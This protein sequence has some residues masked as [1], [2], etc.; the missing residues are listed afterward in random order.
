MH[1]HPAI[2]HLRRALLL[3]TLLALTACAQQQPSKP[4]KTPNMT[5]LS[6]RIQPLFEKTKT[7]CF[8][9]F[10]IDVPA[11]T[12]IVWGSVSVP[13]GVVIAKGDASKLDQMVIRYETELKAAVRFPRTKGVNQYIETIGGPMK[14]Q[15]TV[16]GY[17]GF[18]G[19]GLRIYSYLAMGPDLVQLDALPMEKNKARAI[20]TLNDMASRLRPRNEDE[21]P[22]EPGMCIEH[23]F[24]SDSPTDGPSKQDLIQIG[25]RL[26]EF[27]DVHL[28]IQLSP[29]T[30]AFGES[31]TFKYQMEKAKKQD[32]T[33]YFK[34]KYLREGSGRRIHE[35]SDGY[36]ALTRT[37]DEASSKSHHAFIMDFQGVAGDAL[38]PYADIQL[39][40][41]VSG[42][43][44]GRDGAGSAK[45][46]ITD[47]EALAIWDKITSTIRVRPTS[48]PTVKKT[49]DAGPLLPLGELAATGRSCPQTGVWECV[50]EGNIQDGRRRTIRVG[51]TMPSIVQIGTPS[52]W[53]QIKGETPTHRSATVWKLVGYDTSLPPASPA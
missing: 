17:E 11:A 15:K 20:G 49:S 31:N 46:S 47:E 36:E 38:K 24:L 50:D 51:E 26:K 52:M 44:L 27:P 13:L 25:F 35:W 53:Q 8:G 29:P 22:A 42:S 14:D 40:S 41:G 19:S 16:V 21:V 18:D 1:P 2:H 9:R 45:P 7:V 12:E 10:L 32:P 28:S 5:T 33:S 30:P 3:S 4:W 34:Q 48:G 39:S 43:G 6:P 23:A 37:P